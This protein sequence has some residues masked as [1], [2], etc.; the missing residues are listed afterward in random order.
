MSSAKS[1]SYSCEKGVHWIPFRLFFVACLMVQSTTR[2]NSNGESRQPCLTPVVMLKASV[3]WPS[4]VLDDGD[5]F[6]WYARVARALLYPGFLKV[7]KY[8]TKW[9]L[10]LL[11]LL[12]DDP[13]DCYLVGTWSILPQSSLVVSASTA[14]LTAQ[15]VEHLR[16]CLNVCFKDLHWYIV[17]AWGLLFLESMMAFLISSFDGHLQSTERGDFSRLYACP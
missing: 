6:L 15:V 16:G 9:W 11:W 1:K 3:S 13:Q 5:K 17:W 8:C 4:C 10:K 14:T 2:R 12:K 7:Q